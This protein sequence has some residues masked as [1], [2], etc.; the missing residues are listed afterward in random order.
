MIFVTSHKT[1]QTENIN[2][3]N[4]SNVV[5]FTVNSV[6]SQIRFFNLD[7]KVL[8]F[9]I[10]QDDWFAEH[11]FS[12]VINENILNKIFQENIAKRILKKILLSNKM[13]LSKIIRS[14]ANERFLNAFNNAI[15][16]IF[17]IDD[18]IASICVCVKI[19]S[20]LHYKIN[21]IWSTL[22]ELILIITELRNVHKRNENR[23]C[24]RH[25]RK[26]IF[27]TSAILKSLSLL[28]FSKI[29][30]NQE[31]WTFSAIIRKNNNFFHEKIIKSY[32]SMI[33]KRLVNAFNEFVKRI[34]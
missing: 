12:F 23:I 9:F 29:I 5:S 33:I 27:L 32:I 2:Q 28:S 4:K 21:N 15:A 7:K 22:N 13:R 11:E 1:S 14:E 30:V 18:Y 24:L 16:F 31:I 34:K 20:I 19:L 3:L 6:S 25:W 17:D 8:V 26:M 10:N